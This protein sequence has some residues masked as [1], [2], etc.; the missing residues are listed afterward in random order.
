[1]KVTPENVK[2]DG[3]IGIAAL[4]DYVLPDEYV[5]L[6]HY[7]L[8]DAVTHSVEKTWDM[9]LL[10]LRLMGKM[11]SLEVSVKNISGPLS[12]AEFAGRSAQL[13]MVTF[14]SFLAL[15]SISLGVLNLLPVPMLDGGHLLFYL[16]EWL[17][18]SPLDDN[19]QSLLQRVG[20]TLILMLMSVA[21]V[22]DVGRL[23]G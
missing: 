21:L 13:G 16:I 18:G 14:I 19:A 22:N 7:G 9:S 3:R 2:G 10:T 5:V 15:V 8:F 17:K 11:L 6:E 4:Q 1:V 12:I 20:L 23:L